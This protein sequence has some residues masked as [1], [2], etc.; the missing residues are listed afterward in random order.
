MPSK[1]IWQRIRV[2]NPTRPSVWWG[3]P[4]IEPGTSRTLSENHAARPNPQLVPCWKSS[5]RAFI[6]IRAPDHTMQTNIHLFVRCLWKICSKM[7]KQPK[8]QSVTEVCRYWYCDLYVWAWFCRSL[9]L[10]QARRKL[11]LKSAF[12]ELGC[13]PISQLLLCAWLLA[14]ILY[15]SCSLWAAIIFQ[16]CSNM[17]QWIWVKK[18]RKILNVVIK[19]FVLDII[20]HH[21]KILFYVPLW[22]GHTAWSSLAGLAWWTNEFLCA[23]SAIDWPHTIAH[24]TIASANCQLPAT[25]FPDHLSQTTKIQYWIAHWIHQYLT[26]VGCLGCL[27]TAFIAFDLMDW[28]LNPTP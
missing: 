7:Q 3:I 10:Q 21:Q 20:H 8:L 17:V 4:G 23:L 18:G 12:R 1:K 25:C 15:H 6:S 9:A 26:S 13:T 5:N 24:S 28:Q 2:W 14:W 19:V 16:Y 27:Y 22:C 11:Q